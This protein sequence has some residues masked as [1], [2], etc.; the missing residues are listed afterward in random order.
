MCEEGEDFCHPVVVVA[1]PLLSIVALA[2]GKKEGEKKKDSYQ[3]K[4]VWQSQNAERRL[5]G[6][7][8]R[9]EAGRFWKTV[10][11]RKATAIN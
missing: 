2:Q 11:Q 4:P 6:L 1:A 7:S 10:G 8:R 3:Q 5:N 9:D